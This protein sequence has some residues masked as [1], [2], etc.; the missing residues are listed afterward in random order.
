MP[1]S[2]T[3]GPVAGARNA[4][5]LGLHESVYL[6]SVP[7]AEARIGPGRLGSGDRRLVA[8]SRALRSLAM[9]D[10]RPGRSLEQE[11]PPSYW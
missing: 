3:R 9:S 8:D 6:V 4:A 5:D 7:A 2:C 1:G 10:D 11:K